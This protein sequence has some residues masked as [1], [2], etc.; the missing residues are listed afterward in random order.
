[1]FRELNSFGK[2]TI[3]CSVG[4]KIIEFKYSALVNFNFYLVANLF[5]K[6]IILISKCN[7]RKSF[8]SIKVVFCFKFI[9]IR[10]MILFIGKN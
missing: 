1:M 9:K 2:E 8:F 4:I 3:Q 6:L 7:V 10:F 5:S